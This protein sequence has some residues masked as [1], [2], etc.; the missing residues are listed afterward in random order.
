MDHVFRDAG[1]AAFG[2][3]RIAGDTGKAVMRRME[4]PE[5]ARRQHEEGAEDRRNDTVQA[6]GSERRVMNRLVQRRE[7]KHEDGPVDHH[8]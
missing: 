3:F 7:Q 1:G 2:K 8:A 4:M 5:V 6:L